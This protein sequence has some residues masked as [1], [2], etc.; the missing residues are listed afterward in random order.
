LSGSPALEQ[1][2]SRS[3]SGGVIPEARNPRYTVGAAAKAVTPNRSSTSHV[4]RAEKPASSS[5]VRRPVASGAS[6]A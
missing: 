3:P 2:R 1:V 6:R 5:S 4:D